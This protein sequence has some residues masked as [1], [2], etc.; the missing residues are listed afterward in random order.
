M[1]S[2]EQPGYA[3]SAM[4]EDALHQFDNIIG[5][6]K[7]ERDSEF[8]G[9]GLQ[10]IAQLL[11]DLRVTIQAEDIKAQEKDKL[12]CLLP[13][14]TLQF[15]CNLFDSESQSLRNEVRKL[16][17][18][19]E[20]L[21]LQVTILSDQVEMQTQKITELS[22][23]NKE[24]TE[25]VFSSEESVKKE[26]LACNDYEL[27]VKLLK[28][29]LEMQARI[30]LNA[31]SVQSPLKRRQLPQEVTT[32]DEGIVRDDIDGTLKSNLRSM[33]P[34]ATSTPISTFEV[35]NTDFNVN[36]PPRSPTGI[37]NLFRKSSKSPQS[38]SMERLPAMI[39][40]SN[41]KSSS[42]ADNLENVGVSSPG[43]RRVQ[44]SSKSS[45]SPN[46][47]IDETEISPR[48]GILVNKIKEDDLA[49]QNRRKHGIKKFFSSFRLRRTHSSTLHEPDVSSQWGGK[50]IKNSG[51]KASTDGSPFKRGGFR[52]TAGPRLGEARP[53]AFEPKSEPFSQW[54]KQDICQWFEAL[55]LES[56]VENCKRYV[57]NGR[58]LL[59]ATNHD[60]ERELG[61]HNPL[62]KKKL[63]L[64]VQAIGDEHEVEGE[65]IKGLGMDHTAVT[66]WLDD[67]GLPQY[68]DVFYKARIDCRVLHH[69]TI[70]D[71]QRL[72]IS[73]LL[74]TL[75]L[76]R[77]I[78]T[79]RNLNFDPMQLKRRPVDV[80]N[81]K[82]EVYLWTNHRVMEWLRSI[83][84]AEF[85]P[86]LRGSGVHGSLMVFE[87]QFTGE[88]FA[89]LLHIPTNKSLLRR[90][91]VCKFKEI[92]PAEQMTLKHKEA[93]P[94]GLNVMAKI[95][96]GRKSLGPLAR[97]R[98]FGGNSYREFSSSEYVCPIET[99]NSIKD[100]LG[101]QR[102]RLQMKEAK[103]STRFDLADDA[104]DD[105]GNVRVAELDEHATKKI[106]IF[107]AEIATLT[108]KW[109]ED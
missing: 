57:V 15:F 9:D 1:D 78:Y 37:G 19:N 33:E 80:D 100:S 58:T 65:I 76:R 13:S 45:S 44:Q 85:A 21:S 7:S 55:G 79:L 53:K 104:S 90:H 39:G 14:D 32:P 10:G 81:E 93:S 108:N 92:I 99:K 74:H 52:A 16:K 4:L 106:G 61:I 30:P 73:N 26:K 88:V 54:T 28:D 38:A 63:L 34:T 94:H 109:S 56:Y 64:S 89:S 62:H 41:K 72:K 91:L 60:I 3:A 17:S 6:G 42:Q 43:L 49:F 66:R 12:L 24:L 22:E 96:V 2:D 71:L 77:A 75:S 98:S 107:S 97:L 11:D 67:I 84:L 105:S 69:L 82:E 48:K 59:N 27:K 35:R 25:K 87:P 101:V 8:F 46:L 29:Q 20:T 102:R 23:S 36:T 40:E 95:K 86:N 68:K 50:T 70:A 51:M 5:S 47:V 103:K 31:E 18:E 83:D